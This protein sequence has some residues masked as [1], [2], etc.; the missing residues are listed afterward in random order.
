MARVIASHGTALS[1]GD[2]SHKLFAAYYDPAD[3]KTKPPVGAQD[4]IDLTIDEAGHHDP[5]YVVPGVPHA[6][7]AL[8]VSGAPGAYEAEGADLPIGELIAARTWLRVASDCAVAPKLDLPYDGVVV[9][10]GHDAAGTGTDA[11][12]GI[13]S[14]GQREVAAGSGADA[15]SES[16]SATVASAPGVSAAAGSGADADAGGGAAGG[17]EGAAGVGADAAS[18]SGIAADVAAASG[19][20]AV[21]DGAS[22][23]AGEREGAAGSGAATDSATGA[24]TF[25]AGASAPGQVTGLALTPGSTSIAAAWTVPS[26]SP[27]SYHVQ[28]K[29]HTSG[30][31]L[32]WDNGTPDDPTTNAATITGLTLGVA[33]DVQVRAHNTAGDGSYS[34]TTTITTIY[35]YYL[36]VVGDADYPDPTTL[37]AFSPS[38]GV[39]GWAFDT[40]SYGI[41]NLA[42]KVGTG[43]YT[44]HQ[45]TRCGALA[46]NPTSQAGA[47]TVTVGAWDGVV[48][49]AEWAWELPSAIP[50]GGSVEVHLVYAVDGD[51]TY[52]WFDMT[53]GSGGTRI[54][55]S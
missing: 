35:R 13:G 33:Y 31:W 21:A 3:G 29:A 44:A 27:T 55:V 51:E 7:W 50:S 53:V 54:E 30:T 12:S 19:S 20:G 32:D 45:F 16:G 26:G 8:D 43:E 48:P 1:T 15:D 34:T 24:A 37:V 49:S 23:A 46:F 22:G 40:D 18:A 11:D 2:G 14:A 17:R 41:S 38:S 10:E 52:T 25:V 42:V 5:A 39:G 28:Y 36:P 47:T 4:W 9:I 6:Q